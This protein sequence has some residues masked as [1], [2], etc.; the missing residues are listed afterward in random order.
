MCFSL[1]TD[2][3]LM[4]FSMVV[5]RG[6]GSSNPERL[7]VSDDEIRMI[8]ASEVATTIREAIPEMFGFVRTILIETFYERYAAITEAD[9]AA[10]TATLDAVR[11]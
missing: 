8:V 4:C 5:T 2:N 3:F 10:A 1:F 6:L 11:P 7:S 9:V